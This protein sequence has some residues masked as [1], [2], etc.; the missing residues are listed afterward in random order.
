MSFNIAFN[1]R[2]LPDSNPPL[3]FSLLYFV[4]QIIPDDGVAVIALNIGV[5]IA[6]AVAVYVPSQRL[7]LSGLAIAGIAAFVLSG[8]VLY[9]VPEGRSYLTA[10]VIVFVTCWHVALAIISFPPQLTLI[11]AAILGCLGALT[12]VYAALFCGSL[13]AGLLTL[14]LLFRRKELLKP[15]L[16]LGLS[17]SIVFAIWFGFAHNA[18]HRIDR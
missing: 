17:A 11:R 1:E 3:Y 13:A 14:A 6:A 4:R 18:I 12:H 2:I 10:L 9:F 5:I 16:A 7:G 15:G 8:P